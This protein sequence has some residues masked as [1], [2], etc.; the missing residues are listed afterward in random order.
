MNENKDKNKNKKIIIFILFLM[1]VVVSV[2]YAWFTWQSSNTTI[3]GSTDCF[4]I[5]YDKGSDIG[6]NDNPSN[7]RPV[8]DYKEGDNVVLSIN[9]DS[10]CNVTGTGKIN[11]TTTTFD[12]E[13]GTSAFSLSNSSEILKYKVVKV[14]GS[15]E[16]EVSGCSGNVNSLGTIGLC[17]I[18][19]TS[20]V[21]TYKVY[22]YMDCNTATIDYIGASYVGYIQTAVTQDID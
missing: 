16:T 1:V 3:S 11:L 2:T 10:S 5:N 18:S 12:L 13:N 7:L 8:C 20:N 15:T 4:T 22:L 17:D 9:V 6:S 14:S 21:D 19:V